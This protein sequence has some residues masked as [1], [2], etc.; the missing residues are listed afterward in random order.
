MEE[1]AAILQLL[2]L[3][4]SSA[5]DCRS[6][7]KLDER[8]C[9]RGTYSEYSIGGGGGGCCGGGK[10]GC[11]GGGGGGGSSVGGGGCGGGGGVG[12]AGGVRV[13]RRLSSHLASDGGGGCVGPGSWLLL[14]VLSRMRRSRLLFRLGYDAR[15]SAGSGG[16]RGWGD[17]FRGG[18]GAAGGVLGFGS[19]RLYDAAGFVTESTSS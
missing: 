1:A 9:G 12:G 6:C 14:L 5:R 18:A 4:A 19:S 16:F 11:G 3:A 2:R 8:A 10:G 17:G 13:N 7:N 15:A